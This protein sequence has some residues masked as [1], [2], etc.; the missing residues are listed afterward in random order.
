MKYELLIIF[1]NASTEKTKLERDA[2]NLVPRSGNRY[3]LQNLG[4]KPKPRRAKSI[5][6]A[7]KIGS[8]Y[9]FRN[10]R[11]QSDILSIFCLVVSRAIQSQI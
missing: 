3:A 7:T 8:N 1:G 11:A 9:Q 6:D 10:F 4:E 5:C 2:S